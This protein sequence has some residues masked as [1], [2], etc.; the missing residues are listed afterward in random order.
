MPALLAQAHVR[1]PWNQYR[2]FTAYSLQLRVAY[3]VVTIMSSVHDG[4][5]ASQ[6][7]NYQRDIRYIFKLNTWILG[8]LGIWPIAIKGIG[9][10]ASKIVIVI[11]NLALSFAIVPCAL[12]IIYDEKDIISRLK[13]CGLLA[14]CLTAMTKYCILAIRRPKILRCIEC[15]KSDWWQVGKRGALITYKIHYKILRIELSKIK[16]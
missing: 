7:T 16:Q 5:T 11:F 2:V 3:T 15:I 4:H 9:R 10:H 6:N 13:L 14:F 12:H 1:Q 8:S